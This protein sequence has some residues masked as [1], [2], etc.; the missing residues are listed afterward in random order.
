MGPRACLVGCVLFA[1]ASAAAAPQRPAAPAIAA[2]PTTFVAFGGRPAG[3]RINWA[4]VPGAARYRVRWSNGTYP[5]E[6]MVT[7][8]AVERLE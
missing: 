2:G 3:V 1:T 6:L 5:V 8:P 7:A 4:P